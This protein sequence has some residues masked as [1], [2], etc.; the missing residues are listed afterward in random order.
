MRSNDTTA[1]QPLTM[2]FTEG[3]GDLP[4]PGANANAGANALVHLVKRGRL[5]VEQVPRGLISS[6]RPAA[7]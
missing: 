2:V 4:T 1:Y 3:V 7:E 6:R 5:G